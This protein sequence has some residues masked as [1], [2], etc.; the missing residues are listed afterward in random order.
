M[1][2]K[3]FSLGDRVKFQLTEDHDEVEGIVIMLIPRHKLIGIHHS[4]NNIVRLG[5]HVKHGWDNNYELISNIEEFHNKPFI[6]VGL[7]G[8]KIRII[9]NTTIKHISPN[10]GCTCTVC[11][12][13]SP[14]AEPNQPDNTFKCYSCRESPL[15]A[16]Y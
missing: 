7:N 6:S 10:E 3:D 8:L 15:R 14:M 16:Y 13:Y 4:E 9:S 12:Q 5:E 2:F 11:L 1:E